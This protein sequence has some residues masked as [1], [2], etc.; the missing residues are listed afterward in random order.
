MSFSRRALRQYK[1]QDKYRRDEHSGRGEAVEFLTAVC[2]RFIEEVPYD[3]TQRPGENERD[4]EQCRA[5]KLSE[6]VKRRDCQK[7]TAENGSGADVSKP[8]AICRPIPK[9]SP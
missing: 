9:S 6:K 1:Y 3:R 4:P 2:G 7:Q 8:G 5:G